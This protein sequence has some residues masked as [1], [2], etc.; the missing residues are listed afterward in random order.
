MRHGSESKMVAELW[1]VELAATVIAVPG[2]RTDM[3]ASKQ[4]LELPKIGSN[5][6]LLKC[7]ALFYLGTLGIGWNLM[8]LI[9]RA[10]LLVVGN[11]SCNVCRALSSITKTT[12]R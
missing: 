9:I 12:K 7:A 3:T 5:K 8:I 11:A 4:G 10:L 1:I 2:R 6:M